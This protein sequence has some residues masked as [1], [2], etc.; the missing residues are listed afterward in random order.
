MMLMMMHDADRICGFGYQ[1]ELLYSLIT[2]AQNCNA[3]RDKIKR[4]LMIVALVISAII[5]FAAHNCA[6]LK[7]GAR[8]NKSLLIIA[9]F[10]D[11]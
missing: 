9:G 10:C 11:D 4:R 2:I 7:C 5:V 6:E 8:Q 1:R 3:A